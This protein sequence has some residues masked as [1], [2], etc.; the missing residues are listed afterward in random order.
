MSRATEDK[1]NA[2]H[3]LVAETL[4]NK[5]TETATM[6]N[7]AGEEVEINM[8]DAAIINSAIKFLK[9]NDITGS[10]MDDEN[11][12][13]LREKLQ[14]LQSGRGKL[15]LASDGGEAVNG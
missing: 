5:L 10:V 9:D 11:L 12:Q 7:E 13:G 6:V 4:A 14:D 1:L 3:G 8:A 15:R 2:L